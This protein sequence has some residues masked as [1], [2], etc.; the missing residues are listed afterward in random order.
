MHL[1]E[2]LSRCHIV[3]TLRRLLWTFLVD[4][5][6]H[7]LTL[8][9]VVSRSCPNAPLSSESH[10][11]RTRFSVLSRL[12]IKKSNSMDPTQLISLHDQ[13]I[14]NEVLRFSLPNSAAAAESSLLFV[15]L[16]NLVSLIQKTIHIVV[17]WIKNLND[18]EKLRE[19]IFCSLSETRFLCGGSIFTAWFHFDFDLNFFLRCGFFNSRSLITL[20]LLTYGS[21]W[22]RYG[23]KWEFLN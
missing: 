16:F 11:K 23:F 17:F 15:S 20:S 21:S 3:E 19:L 10:N 7:A 18:I 6:L 8:E 13:E 14:S 9:P 22:E 4:C 12:V 1:R 5:V 2:R